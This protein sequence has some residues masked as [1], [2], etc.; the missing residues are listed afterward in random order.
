MSHKT[1]IGSKC[2]AFPACPEV[3]D[4]MPRIKGGEREEKLPEAEHK[5][6]TTKDSYRKGSLRVWG[7]PMVRQPRVKTKAAN[8]SIH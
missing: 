7:A 4:L 2:R 3:L 6:S 8:W 1:A 5:V